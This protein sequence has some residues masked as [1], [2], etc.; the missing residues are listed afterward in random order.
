MTTA[1]P[2]TSLAR[3]LGIIVQQT[4]FA[5]GRVNNLPSVVAVFGQGSTGT[6]YSTDKAQVFSASEVG[7]TYGYGSPLHLAMEQLFPSDGRPGVTGVPVIVYP[8]QDDGAG[9]AADGS[10]TATGTATKTASYFVRAAGILSAQFTVLDGEDGTDLE[11]RINDAINAVIAMPITSVVTLDVVDVTSKWKGVSANDIVVEVIG[12][13]NGITFGI[14]QPTGGAANPLLTTALA[15]LGNNWTTHPI[16]CMEPTDT[17][18]LDAFANNN[19]GRWGPLVRRMYQA[20]VGST[21]ASVTTAIAVTDARKTDRT[22]VQIPAP[23]SVNLPLQIAARAVAQIAGRAQNNPPRAYGGLQLTGLIPGTD[24]EQW[25]F[26]Q[27]DTAIKGGSGSTKVIDSVIELDNVVTMYYPTG[28]N[29][30]IYRYV[31]DIT[32]IQNV[33]FN[34]D[35]LYSTD[36]WGSAVLIPDGQATTNTAAVRP[37]TAKTNQAAL[38]DNLGLA[39]IISDP[40]FTKANQVANINPSNPKRLD[41]TFPIKLAGN[42]EQRSVDV[43]AS[44]FFGTKPLL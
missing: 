35:I 16:N 34:L 32:K 14:V 31:N 30:P 15:Q 44:F 27:A 36:P 23:G 17:V 3:A 33:V 9:A 18:T 24:G 2:Q 37:S 26:N 40:D 22:N 29:N 39:A 7:D 12:P 11:D 20:F 8:L 13:D 43:L 19:E 10:I 5:P 38:A 4:E 21:E 1:I 28:D 6:V 42:D 25:D 41:T